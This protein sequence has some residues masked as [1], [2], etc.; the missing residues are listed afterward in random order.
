[1][2]AL[3]CSALIPHAFC[4]CAKVLLVILIERSHTVFEIESWEF[5]LLYG[6]VTIQNIHQYWPHHRILHCGI[7]PRHYIYLII[8]FTFTSVYFKTRNEMFAAKL[9][10]QQF[11]IRE[12][13]ELWMEQLFSKWIF[14][15]WYTGSWVHWFVLGQEAWVK[16]G[17]LSSR[18]KGWKEIACSLN[19]RSEAKFKNLLTEQISFDSLK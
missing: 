12:G 7:N 15:T 4:I 11:L 1:M 17:H 8:G 16:R 2:T 19:Q 9:H 18:R 13:D 5:V 6:W 10:F 14:K 3:A